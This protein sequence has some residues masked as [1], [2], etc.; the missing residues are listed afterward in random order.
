MRRLLVCTLGSMLLLGCEE[1][2][3]AGP[4]TVSPGPSWRTTGAPPPSPPAELVSDAGTDLVLPAPTAMAAL[5]PPDASAAAQDA[6]VDPDLAPIEEGRSA[7]ARCFGAGKKGSRRT[8]QV[9]A[10]VMPSGSVSRAEV[11]APGAS[12][13]EISCLKRVASGLRFAAKDVRT[14]DIDIEA[15]AP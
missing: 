15:V 7:G 4:I 6:A 8:A 3:A 12:E 5:A 11:S 9:K 10:Y 2:K 14:V 1:K 13:A